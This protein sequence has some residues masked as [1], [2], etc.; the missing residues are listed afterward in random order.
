MRFLTLLLL[1]FSY[2][3][4]QQ[5][6]V[7]QSPVERFPWRE[8]RTL[9]QGQEYS[10]YRQPWVG[11]RTKVDTYQRSRRW[12]RWFVVSS[13]AAIGS[14][15]LYSQSR[16]SSPSAGSTR[17]I[18]LGVSGGLLA[19]EFLTNRA[20]KRDKDYSLLNIGVAGSFAALTVRDQLKE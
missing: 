13:F 9:I 20:G 15:L 6:P 2:A 5:A 4:A 14:A 17:A 8:D 7:P 18:S 10:T 1:C 12:Q 3:L 11:Y 19:F 16:A